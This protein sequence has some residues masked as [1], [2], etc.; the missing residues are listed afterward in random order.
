MSVCAQDA[1]VALNERGGDHWK[2]IGPL[3]GGGGSDNQEMSFLIQLWWLWKL[4][5]ESFFQVASSVINDG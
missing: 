2:D 1:A 4:S 5:L 3:Q